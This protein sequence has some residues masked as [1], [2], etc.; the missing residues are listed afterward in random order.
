M[1]DAPLDNDQIGAFARLHGS[2]VGFEAQC[3]SPVARG[4]PERL[5]RRQRARVLSVCNTVGAS[6]PRESDAVLYTHDHAVHLHGIDDLR[7]VSLRRGSL[8]LYGPPETLERLVARFHYIFD[9][10][11]VPPEGTSRPELRPVPVEPGRAVTVA[12]VTVLFVA[13]SLTDDDGNVGRSLRSDVIARRV[14]R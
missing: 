8:P 9:P 12:G 10:T 6:I 4:H 14:Q 11:H 5:P 3:P 13:A 7:A 1:G 2:G